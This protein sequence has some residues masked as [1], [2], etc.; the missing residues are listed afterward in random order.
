MPPLTWHW[1]CDCDVISPDTNAP[2]MSWLLPVTAWSLLCI[3]PTWP[4]SCDRDVT[5]PVLQVSGVISVSP[6]WD[7]SDNGWLIGTQMGQAGDKLYRRKTWVTGH[8]SVRAQ[9]QWCRHRD[10]GPVWD[11]VSRYWDTAYLAS[12]PSR[13][14]HSVVTRAQRGQHRPVKTRCTVTTQRTEDTVITVT[15]IERCEASEAVLVQRSSLTGGWVETCVRADGGKHAVRLLTPGTRSTNWGAEM[16]TPWASSPPV[17]HDW[18]DRV[19]SDKGWGLPG[20]SRHFPC[21]HDVST[22]GLGRWNKVVSLG[23]N[24]LCKFQQCWQLGGKNTSLDDINI[25]S[26]KNMSPVPA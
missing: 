13:H 20:L 23:S 16:D 24:S 15:R 9:A 1:C 12:S 26:G 21:P 22:R 17:M 10:P 14:Q 5:W 4:Q 8:V 3:L 11:V 7:I 6:G 2:L 19:T 18:H 25:V